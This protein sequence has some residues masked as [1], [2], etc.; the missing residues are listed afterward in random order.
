MKEQ[1]F[2]IL[3][4]RLKQEGYSITQQRQD[5]F[6][7]I[8]D[9]GPLSL[10]EII[11]RVAQKV[12]RVSVYRIV[13][14]Y[15][16]LGIVQRVNNGF[17]YKLELS[18]SFTAHHHHLTCNECGKIIN[19]NENELEQ[20]INLIAKEKHFKPSSHQIEI[21]GRCIDCQSRADRSATTPS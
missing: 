5:V 11:R 17:K 19:I 7:A 13:G 21:Q 9:Y 8:L 20:F 15:E 12:D 10:S 18:D 2:V 14:L 16:S 6:K 3:E 1:S 4:S